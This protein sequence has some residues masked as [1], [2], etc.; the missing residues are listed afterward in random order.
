M[1]RLVAAALWSLVGWYAGAV[2][3]WALDLSPALG[4]IL[5][6]ALAGIVVADPRRIIWTHPGSAIEDH[7]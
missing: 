7:S 6:V 1:K 5:A 2:G 4:P 3:A